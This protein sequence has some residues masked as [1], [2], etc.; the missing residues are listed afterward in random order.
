MSTPSR[1]AH[2]NARH[3]RRTVGQNWARICIPAGACVRVWL[4]ACN[5]ARESRAAPVCACDRL[6]RVIG[7][8]VES[9]SGGGARALSTTTKQ[10]RTIHTANDRHYARVKESRVRHAIIRAQ[11]SLARIFRE[12]SSFLPS[13]KML[14]APNRRHLSRLGVEDFIRE[15]YF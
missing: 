1:A 15:F 8:R 10:G 9:R 2:A 11:I 6:E 3:A 13:G 5:D 7:T 12:N 14:A 4:V